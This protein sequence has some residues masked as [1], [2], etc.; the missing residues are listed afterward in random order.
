[1]KE[2]LESIILSGLHK[3]AIAKGMDLND[4]KQFLMF[5]HNIEAITL[6]ASKLVTNL[7]DNFSCGCGKSKN[8]TMS[9]EA[10]EEMQR[11]NKHLGSITKQ[12][13]TKVVT[14]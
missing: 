11:R 6:Q 12:E 5:S 1:M 4:E 10:L 8:K 14:V 13:T 9:K 3:K 2:P 7:V